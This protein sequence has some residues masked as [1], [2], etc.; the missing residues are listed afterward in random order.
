MKHITR[1]IVALL[2]S[3]VTAITTLSVSYSEAFAETSQDS[4]TSTADT[5]YEVKTGGLLGNLMTD[6]FK[7]LTKENEETQNDDYAVYRIDFDEAQNNLIV[8]YSAKED[9]T[10]FVGF[11][12]DEGT[13]LYTS[14]TKALSAGVEQYDMLSIPEIQSKYYT[15][16]A[17]MVGG[18][19]EP[20][21]SPCENRERTK[22]IQE[23]IDKTTDDFEDNKIIR[24]SDDDDYNFIVAKNEFKTIESSETKDT[25][26]GEDVENNTVTF[27]NIDKIKD[28]KVGQDVLVKAN[29]NMLFFRVGKININ[30]NTAVVTREN[31][32]FSDMVDFVKFDFSKY[33][34][35]AKASIKNCDDEL[36]SNYYVVDEKEASNKI[37]TDNKR[38]QI[39]PIALLLN[40]DHTISHKFHYD[41]GELASSDEKS[42]I[43]GYFEIGI[44]IY[45]YDDIFNMTGTF[46]QLFTV[47]LESEIFSH[48][49]KLGE[50]SI[51]FEPFSLSF[52]PKI[53]LS[54]SGTFTYKY[55]IAYDFDIDPFGASKVTEHEPHN[56]AE[57]EVK[58][59][60]SFGVDIG[61]NFVDDDVFRVSIEPEIGVRL[62]CEN[63]DVNEN[64]YTRH[65]CSNCVAISLSVFFRVSLHFKILKRELCGSQILKKAI[66]NSSLEDEDERVIQQWHIRNGMLYDGPCDNTSHKIIIHVKEKETD[67]SG[68]DILTPVSGATAYSGNYVS[69]GDKFV[70]EN[71]DEIISNK[72][73]DIE[74]WV[75]DNLLGDSD[76]CVTVKSPDNK[77]ATVRVGKR[78][79]PN[80]QGPNEYGAIIDLSSLSVD[81]DDEESYPLR[82]NCGI[83]TP[84]MI[85]PNEVLYDPVEYLYYSDGECDIFGYGTLDSGRLML[86]L[87]EKGVKEIKKLKI[88]HNV[89]VTDATGSNLSI[90]PI[91]SVEFVSDNGDV[92]GKIFQN[93]Y[94]L[95]EVILSDFY[96]LENEA[97]ANC[98]K[99]EKIELPHNLKRIGESVFRNNISLKEIVCPEKLSSIERDAFWECNELNK[100]VLNYG[101][102][103]ISHD[104]FYDTGIK[105]INIPASVEKIGME[106][107]GKCESLKSVIINGNFET[108]DLETGNVQIF[109]N[110]PVETVIIN[111]GVTDICG[112]LFQSISTL[113]SVRFSKNLKTVGDAA[114]ESTGLTNINLPNSLETIEDAAFHETKLTS[115]RIPP[116]VTTIGVNAFCGAPIK[117]LVMSD[118]LKTIG[119][120]AFSGSKLTSVVVPQSVTSIGSCAFDSETLTDITVLSTD[121]TLNVGFVPKNT[122][123]WGYTG[124]SADAYAHKYGNLFMALDTPAVTTTTAATTTVT[125]T[126]TAVVSAKVAPSA[127]CVCIAV[128]DENTINGSADEILDKDNVKFFD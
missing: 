111:D 15:V 34:G 24:F 76:Y 50:I 6:E 90:L 84:S 73:G 58:V 114:F 97:F 98:Y 127:E 89:K 79:N 60:L 23:I 16:K 110:S 99:L 85:D 13:Q 40:G 81:P 69:S 64:D 61:I 38:K 66:D 94:D 117:N 101:L 11:Y 39:P 5:D 18:F 112:R 19:N 121:C 33:K 30:D 88:D 72:N 63:S 108:G 68:K 70:D 7:N 65:D 82:G 49:F 55:S 25:V 46:E 100:V 53:N 37:D 10:L 91:E 31:T 118:G 115:V 21:T 27:T 116:N 1:K 103:T 43:S 51:P 29:D 62:T 102:R 74:L 107:F 124:S 67:S 71:D 12:N 83:G 47:N 75:K 4:S 123:I 86:G 48:E 106:A 93:K 42:K 35:E 32:E 14:L 77:I 80:C 9:C 3:A 8:S 28:I 120:C 95:K 122:T 105:S 113:K 17:F 54:V 104:A 125:T 2:A 59:E 44:K 96:E 20:L 126:T 52:I 128:K 92:L 26:S 22:E 45:Y 119:S 36:V 78:W 57:G 109:S 87:R 41:I 56:E